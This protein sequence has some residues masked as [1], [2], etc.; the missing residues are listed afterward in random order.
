M[1]VSD[2]LYTELSVEEH[3]KLIGKVGALKK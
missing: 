1:I 3:L 2:I